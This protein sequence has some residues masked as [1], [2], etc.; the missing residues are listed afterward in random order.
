MMEL[1][2]EI[3]DGCVLNYLVSPQYN[4]DAI[5]AI[6]RG[7]ARPA[8]RSTI[9][10]VRNSSSAASTDRPRRWTPLASSSPSTSA[11]SRTS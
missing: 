1:T 9:S 8:E 11:S 6:E 4:V 3:A 10:I 2:G 5:K 7:A